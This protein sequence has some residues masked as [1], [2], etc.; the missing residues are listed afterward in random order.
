M[1]KKIR[2]YFT[3]MGVALRATMM[4]RGAFI[5]GFF[6]PL[7][8]QGGRFLTASLAVRGRI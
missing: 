8:W 3:F 5:A 7:L 4:H 6:G 2:L 1:R